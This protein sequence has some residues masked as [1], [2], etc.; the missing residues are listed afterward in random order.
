MPRSISSLGATVLFVG[1]LVSPALADQLSPPPPGT[2]FEFGG[3]VGERIKANV[4]NWLVPAPEANPGII[5][6]FHLR[7]R[8]PVPQLVPWA[9]EFVGKYLIGAVQ[10]LRMS[11]SEALREAVKRTFEQLYAAQ[12]TDGYLGPFRKEE[13]LLGHWDL[14]GHY[15]IMLALLMWHDEAKFY[16]ADGEK[17]L[18]CAR[19]MADLMCAVYLNTERRPIQA[20]SE[21]MN[22]SAIHSLGVLYRKTNEQRYID[23]MR[24][25]EEDWQKSGDYL[26]QGLANVPFYKTPKPRW[27]SLHAM[28]G[29][30]ELYKIT[31]NEDYKTAYVNLWRS[32]RKYDRHNTGGFSTGEQAIGN[33]YTPGAIETC[34]TIAWSAISSDI[35]QLTGDP[36]AADELELSFYNSTLGSQHPSGRWFTYNTPMDGKRE[37]SQHT[38][39]FQS[40]AGTP[41]FNCC[42]ANAARGL[43]M[44]TEW[45]VT[46]SPE[47][48]YYINYLGP[49]KLEIRKK[50]GETLSIEVRSNYPADGKIWV[51]ATQ[52]GGQA[53]PV[54]IRIP[55][56]AKFFQI[57]DG[58]AHSLENLMPIVPLGLDKGARSAYTEITLDMGL[59]TH[60]G[61]GAQ[62]GKISV[63]KGPLLLAFDQSDNAYDIPDLA[64]LDYKDLV[65]NTCETVDAFPALM[66]LRF[67]TKNGNNAVLRDFASAGATGTEYASWIPVEGAPPPDINLTYPADAEK[68][69][70]GANRFTWSGCKHTGDWFYIIEIAKTQRFNEIV[71][72]IEPSS[73]TAAVIREPL[74]NGQQY[75]WRVRAKN[76]GGTIFSPV[77]SFIVDA[78]IK[79][80]F[81]D[82]PA[83][84]E[85]REDG[86]IVG[87]YLDGKAAPVYGHVDFME[88]VSPTPDRHGKAEGAVVFGGDGQVRYRTPGMPGDVYSLSVWF[89]VDGEQPHMAQ[90]FCAWSK[91][92]D[93]PLRIVI[94][95]GQVHARIEGGGGCGTKG[96][97]VVPGQWV[98]AAAVKNGGNL[99]FFIN[100]EM[101]DNVGAPGLLPTQT[102]DVSIGSNPHHTGDEHFTGGIDDLALYA[103]ALSDEE[104]KELAMAAP[105]FELSASK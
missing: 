36:E 34:C 28:Q 14:W 99:K 33:P 88:G 19:K 8:K 35:L 105:N 12:D 101:V 94:D 16:D 3:V 91:Y 78:S 48:A 103:R 22:L 49:M 54:W 73:N 92:G 62:F 70:S 15:H 51:Q 1:L 80:D 37:A 98:H 10:H 31:G 44:L 38:I 39:V 57:G 68:I 5:E 71:Y 17:A 52:T 100:G 84:Y 87:D 96:A 66:A 69:P 43:G 26:R 50:D 29:L 24:V 79:N 60:I 6:M 93:D 58:T 4:D 25:F 41:E 18:N 2:R 53:T 30:G 90:V 83:T 59:R 89:R 104:V 47:G 102:R 81:L 75:F 11:D 64:A 86:L 77:Q 61:D 72:S 82:I 95:D 97:P 40:R 55:G 63:Y 65:V 45:A 76:P 46:S 74:E 21:E 23:L 32:I 13:R 56:W 85:F 67:K 42:S 27:E 9:G 7:D 20:G